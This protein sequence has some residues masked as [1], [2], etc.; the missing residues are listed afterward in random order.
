MSLQS[1]FQW[2]EVSS[3]LLSAVCWLV[4]IWLSL[5]TLPSLS[6]S[7]VFSLSLILSLCI[8][9]LTFIFS[10]ILLVLSGAR[11][12]WTDRSWTSSTFA[13]QSVGLLFLSHTFLF[14]WTW[15]SLASLSS[16]FRA[17]KRTDHAQ[18]YH[19]F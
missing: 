6:L 16:I 5:R 14:E 18:F 7:L 1:A 19:Q 3:L 11:S 4:L 9:F 2:T 8:L 12:K 10:I 13:T 17:T 15:T